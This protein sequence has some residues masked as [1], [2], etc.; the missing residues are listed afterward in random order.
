M[1]NKQV[2]K[3]DLSLGKQQ[4]FKA[5]YLCPRLFVFQLC[6]CRRIYMRVQWDVCCRSNL[7]NIDFGKIQRAPVNVILTVSSCTLLATLNFHNI[8]LTRGGWIDM[9]TLAIYLLE[10]LIKSA[11]NTRMHSWDFDVTL[12]TYST[13][14]KNGSLFI[15]TPSMGSVDR[16]FLQDT[17]ACKLQFNAEL[18]C[19][20]GTLL[21]VTQ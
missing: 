8:I 11:N 18:I 20:N 19:Q 7:K 5:I 10:S 6:I 3:V 17:G 2:N 13:Y 4:L 15:S 1:N 12:V 14:T 9:K 21:T 16:V